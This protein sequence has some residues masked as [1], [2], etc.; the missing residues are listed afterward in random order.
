MSSKIFYCPKKKTYTL[1]KECGNETAINPCP[2]KY[3]PIDRF[4]KYRRIARRS[5]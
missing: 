2:A 5:N 4:S 1:E 3:S